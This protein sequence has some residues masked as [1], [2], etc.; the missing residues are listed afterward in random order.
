MSDELD[1]ELAEWANLSQQRQRLQ[2]SSQPQP[3]AQAQPVV[4]PTQAAPQGQPTPKPKGLLGQANDWINKAWNSEQA[5]NTPAAIAA[6][7][8]HDQAFAAG[9]G[10]GVLR[11]PGQLVGGVMDLNADAGKFIDDNIKSPWVRGA[12][13]AFTLPQH[14]AMAARSGLNQ[15]ASLANT[16][17]MRESLG[18]VGD[19]GVN[20][21]TSQATAIAATLPLGG[22]GAAEDGLP[23]LTKVLKGTGDILLNS[24]KVGLATAA[25]MDPRSGRISDALQQAGVHNALIDYLA[26][27]PNDP[28]VV[29]RLKNGIEGAIGNA[30]IEPIFGLAKGIFGALKGNPEMVSEAADALKPLQPA[31]TTISE[32]TPEEA[33]RDGLDRTFATKRSQAAREQEALQQQA[34]EDGK[35]PPK[36][37]SDQNQEALP[38]GTRH[39]DA[40]SSADPTGDPQDLVTIPPDPKTA[41]ANDANAALEKAGAAERVDPAS[42]DLT[43]DGRIKV[44][45]ATKATLDDA[46]MGRTFAADNEAPAEDS[47]IFKEEDT[48]GGS[49]V[50]GT[51]GKADLQAFADRAADLRDEV[52]DGK[53]PQD[54]LNTRAWADQR[55]ISVAQLGAS[56]DVPAML[57]AIAERVPKTT[58]GNTFTLQAAKAVAD[59]MGVPVTDAVDFAHKF[60]GGGGDLGTAMAT[61]QLQWT[62]MAKDLEDLVGADLM[63]APAATIKDASAKVHNMMTFTQSWAELKAG[64]ANG[65]QVLRLPDAD[66]Y[67]ANVGKY[68][69]EQ[70][71]PTPK[72]T[73][74]PLPRDAGGEELQQWVDLWAATKGDPKSQQALLQGLL[75]PPRKWLYLR[76][77]FANFFTAALVSG[78]QTLLRDLIAPTGLAGLQTLERTAGGAM[79]ALGKTIMGDTEGAR[80]MLAVATQAP[81]SY[82]QTLGDVADAFKY[83]IAKGGAEMP[84]GGALDYSPPGAGAGGLTGHADSPLDFSVRGV[85]KAMIS[86]AQRTAPGVSGQIPYLLG[87][88][89]NKFPQA[90]QALH[91]GLNEMASRL[92]YLGEI[93]AQAYLDAAKEELNP[94]DTAAFVRYRLMN[95][96]DETGAAVDW[97]GSYPN[98][99]RNAQRATLTQP[100]GVEGQTSQKFARFVSGLKQNLPE[101]R[102]VLP[103]FN[104]PA[105]AIG[106]TLRRAPF[107]GQVFKETQ[108]E[109]SGNLGAISQANAYGR[110]LSGGAMMLGGFAMARGGMMTGGGP[111]DPN[112]RRLWLMDH[113]P[114]SIRMGDN[115]VSYDRLGTVGDVLGI[116]S[117]VFDH[118]VY[119]DVDS[120]HGVWAGMA[121]LAQYFKDKSSLQGVASLL[122]FGGD[123]GESQNVLENWAHS[124]EGGFV[125]A[126]VTQLGRNNLDPK[127]RTVRTAFDAVLNRLPGASTLLDPARNVLGEDVYRPQAAGFGV[128]PINLSPANTYAKDPVLD[129]LDRLY[130]ETGYTPGVPSASAGKGHFDM[131]SVKLED[132]Q[133]LYSA[134]LGARQTA[135]VDGQSLRSALK[136]TIDSPEYNAAADGKDLDAGMDSRTG[137]LAK[138]F[139]Q[140]S[141]AAKAQVANSSPLAA[142]WLAVA[143]A[144][145]RDNAA[146]K[147]Y[148]A[149]TLVGNPGLL[150][151]LNVPIEDYEDRIKGQ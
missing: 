52:L 30:A 89:I 62:R 97:D 20:Q 130:H 123:P 124:V 109:L 40:T 73:I 85:P 39:T 121:A 105:N 11:A 118:S 51:M 107:L 1:N 99:F 6:A 100:V 136:E 116:T 72:G 88:L 50:V 16:L 84:S 47:V 64:V 103:I 143:Q 77:S 94:Q 145:D 101:S 148:D 26:S 119:H 38:Q 25:V 135:N 104:V 151:A 42:M 59:S 68:T 41:L 87:N 29:A 57:R 8:K 24:G 13:T 65:L 144:K 33:A 83:A 5:Q 133:S 71:P 93:R 127:V 79:G 56:Y 110:F 70:L 128:L 63:N 61:L 34:V 49:R 23:L 67:L 120:P 66:T 74:P 82:V 45:A 92:A 140:Y 22:E 12:A 134:L 142:R 3:A 21:F 114:Y 60:M 102:Y 91:G 75:V 113:Q 35:E 115:W 141:T 122:N 32:A 19:P 81:A 2:P 43:P 4:Q 96:T 117:S 149:K 9:V 58:Q 10:A 129:E 36:P 44:Q 15:G 139:S 98:A 28:D 37:P 131:R 17:S 146:L 125:P 7:D 138:V 76:N 53:N 78:P 48:Q 27:D 95:S 112:Q 132:G 69:K 111:A 147:A 86:A 18:Q 108:Q 80:E 126:F 137:M 31:Q 54:T 46:G 150:K 55:Q 14:L 106:E 90:I